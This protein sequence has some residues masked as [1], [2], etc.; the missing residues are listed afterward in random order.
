MEGNRG[1]YLGGQI[2]WSARET[3]ILVVI[4]VV[5]TGIRLVRFLLDD[6]FLSLLFAQQN[7][8]LE[9]FRVQFDRAR[10]VVV[11]RHRVG[12]QPRIAVRVHDRDGGR[13]I[14][15]GRSD[16]RVL[17]EVA[18]HHLEH[19]HQVRQSHRVPE[20]LVRSK[21]RFVREQSALRVLAAFDGGLL[22]EVCG[23]EMRKEN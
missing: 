21:Y 17:F 10:R 19:D 6:Q 15:G 13:Q 4:K 12:D 1:N 18:A 20:E 3:N 11:A 9:Q 23:L 14:L 2:R 16:D 7:G 8:L 22:D 5:Q